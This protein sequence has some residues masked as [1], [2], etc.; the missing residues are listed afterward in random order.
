M[1]K[2]YT[3]VDDSR[4]SGQR[5][6]KGPSKKKP[7]LPVRPTGRPKKLKG[8][9]TP[10]L[11]SEPLRRLGPT[12]SKGYEVINFARDV[13][14]EPLLPWQEWLV[15]HALELNPDGT[16]RFRTVISL[17]ARQNGKTHLSKVLALWRLYVDGARLVLGS[18]QDLGISREVLDL[19]NETIDTVPELAEEK[20][21]FLTA[22]GKECLK[23]HSGARYII[24][25]TNRKAGRGL[26]VDHLTMDELREQQDWLGWAALSKTTNARPYAQTWALSNAGD[27]TSVV[28]NHLRAAAGVRQDEYGVAYMDEATDPSIGIFEWSA[29]EGC[30][31]DDEEAWCQANP[32]LGYTLAASTIRSAM[33]T[34]PAAVFRTEVLCQKVD[35]VNTAVDMEA[36]RTLA[37]PSGSLENHRSSV[38]ACVDVAPDGAHIMLTAAAEVSPGV[39]RVEPV[40]AWKDINAAVRELKG[41]LDKVK[42]SKLAWFPGSDAGALAEMLRKPAEHLGIPA[43]KVVAITGVAVSE[44]C[45]GLDSLIRS[46]RVLHPDDRLLNAHLAGSQRYDQ[47]DGW[48][49]ARKGVGHVN[50]AYTAAGALYALR[51]APDPTPIPLPMVI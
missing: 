32:A 1:A 46:R 36:W 7:K 27:D 39:F 21:S 43:D 25:A 17:V 33:G 41:H 44:A 8:S 16:F 10:R 24:R 48:R 29:V 9:T 15:I 42:P 34:D 26:S 35:N 23:L 49:F 38:T 20:H 11:W 5:V 4:P 28:L 40:A 2:V 47:G 14:Q 45:I 19:V 6:V 30:D 13:L 51:V 37:D 31:L 12:T 22:N 50:G 3:V 18:A